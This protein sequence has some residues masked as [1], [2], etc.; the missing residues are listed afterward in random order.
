MHVTSTSADGSVKGKKLGRK[1]TSRLAVEEH[2][3]EGLERPL[4]VGEGD[5]LVDHQP[6]DLVEH[7]RVAE[8]GV[9][10]VDASRD[11]HPDR[12]RASSPWRGSAPARCGCA[13]AAAGQ[14]EGVL[15]VAG[16]V[17]GRDV[18][19]LE[20]VAVVLDL[21]P[22]RDR[23]AHAEEDLLDLAAYQGDRM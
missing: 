18:E 13:A 3:D 4:E 10:A 6:L 1:R 12:R 16:R 5:P 11:D 8:V 19:R 22:V 23:V 9:A 2:V 21:G 14:V 7:R 17:V 15:V 20:V